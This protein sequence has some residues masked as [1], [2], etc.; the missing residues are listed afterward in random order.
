MVPFGQA[1]GGQPATV[2]PAIERALLAGDWQTVLK[3]CSLVDEKSPAVIR[4]LTGHACLA[5]NE[6]DESLRLFMSLSGEKERQQWQKWTADFRARV[7]ALPET[8]A[9]R[10]AV[11]KYLEGDGFARQPAWEQAAKC[12]QEATALDRQSA[13]AWNALGVAYV[14][15]RNSDQD[16]ATECFAEALRIDGKLA[17]AHANTGALYLV[18]EGAATAV[19]EFQKAIDCSKGFSLAR[20]GLACALLGKSR[21]RASIE[22]ARKEFVTAAQ[23]ECVYPLV[24]RNVNRLLHPG[25]TDDPEQTELP[26]GK[27]AGFNAKLECNRVFNA[28][29]SAPPAQQAQVLKDQISHYTKVEQ[30]K[31]A[32]EAVRQARVDSFLSKVPKVEITASTHV[33]GNVGAAAP[34]GPALATAKIGGQQT[35][36]GKITFNPAVSAAENQ[37]IHGMMGG[38]ARGVPGPGGVKID[39]SLQQAVGDIGPWPAKATWFGMA[40]RVKLPETPSY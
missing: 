8:T 34:V 38:A 11:A 10:K 29:K 22:E 4:A 1:A 30:S 6:N 36:G 37:R 32:T 14:L 13:L 33:G 24:V 23:S 12:F 26:I 3:E 19:S 15:K 28:V 20:N 5:L 27:T 31:I 7:D 9:R 39:V 18:L 16:K 17:D 2:S 40:P 35:V 21:G 25:S